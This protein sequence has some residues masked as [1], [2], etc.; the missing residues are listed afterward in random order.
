MV[1]LTINNAQIEVEEGTKLLHAVEKAGVKLPTLCHHKALTPYGACR[2]CVVEVATPGRPASVQAACSYPALD[3]ISV[4]THSERVLRARRI[5]AE[6]LLARSSESEIVK[7]IA[8]E[9]GVLDTRIKKKNDDC[10]YCGLC[11][12]M[13]E[14]RMG[15]AAIGFTGRGPKKKLQAPFGKHN[16]VCWTC[17]A[18]NF[19]CPTGKQV[20]SLATAG[21]F[22]PIRNIFNLNLDSR[23]ATYIPYPQAVPNKALIDRDTC[24]HLNYDDCGICEEVCEAEAINFDQKPST[25]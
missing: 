12:R 9:L 6:L 13:C 21:T 3:G 18:C 2:L 14:E 11:V 23:P 19:I 16:S 8:A 25:V 10:I 24:I 17:G 5:V 20:S 1:R 4:T 22:D 7:R 15:R